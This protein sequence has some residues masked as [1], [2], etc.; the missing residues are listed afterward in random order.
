MP[1]IGTVV[2]SVTVLRWMKQVGDAVKRGDPLCEIETD[3]ATSV[4]ESYAEGVL[5]WQ[6]VPEMSEVDAGSVIAYVG[7]PGED[8][9]EAQEGR[10]QAAGRGAAAPSEAPRRADEAPKV[11]VLIRNL[12][13]RE[14]V[15]LN[16]VVGTGPGGKITREDV[17]RAKQDSPVAAGASPPAGVQE[18]LSDNQRSVVRR[19]SRSWAEIVPINLSVRIGMQAAMA[20]R[21]KTRAERDKAVSYD[22][23]LVHTLARVV[24]SF[25]RFTARLEGDNLTRAD[26]IHIGL[27][28]S[29]G[30]ELYIVTIKRANTLAL[31]ETE[32]AIQELIS[33]VKSRSLTL[34]E[35]AG[36]CLTVSNLGMYAVESFNMII[37]PGQSAALSVGRV[38]EVCVFRNGT[39]HSEHQI[40]AT[41]SVDHRLI[42]GRQA[43]ELLTALKKE[44]EC[45]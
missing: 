1:D 42:N 38:E 35:I 19:I 39:P 15:N 45:L 41:L 43:A 16:E 32:T 26:G 14:G 37:P 9:P 24:E 13:Q 21:E 40:C 34:E 44:M 11:P 17:L 12:A 27:A 20:L 30:E 3:K 5:L 7:R 25:P 10:V 22:A 36:A 18:S 2:D 4:L 8:V 28:V 33:K 6:A 31:A 23:I 29:E